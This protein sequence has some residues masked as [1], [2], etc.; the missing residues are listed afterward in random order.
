MGT[1]VNTSHNQV[2]TLDA[3]A[4]ASQLNKGTS[5]GRA[6]RARRALVRASRARRAKGSGQSK[7]N[8]IDLYPVL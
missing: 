5:G 4:A 3:R 8:P 2:L 1:Q 6:R 7:A